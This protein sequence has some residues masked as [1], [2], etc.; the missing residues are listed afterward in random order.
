MAPASSMMSASMTPGQ[1]L[2]SVIVA[3]PAITAS[4]ISR[5]QAGQSDRVFRGTPNTIG[6]LSQLL[7][8]RRGA[9]VGNGNSPSG[10]MRLTK[11]ESHQPVFDSAHRTRVDIGAHRPFEIIVVARWPR[12]MKCMQVC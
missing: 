7:S 11:L 2:K 10:T 4:A 9:H 8:S 1:S 12:L 6:V 3:L 5:L